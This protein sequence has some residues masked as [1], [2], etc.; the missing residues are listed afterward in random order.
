MSDDQALQPARSAVVLTWTAA[1]SLFVLGV[2]PLANT[3]SAGQAVPWYRHALLVWILIGG[4]A[5]GWISASRTNLDILP[6]GLAADTLSLKL[7][8]Y[9]KGNTTYSRTLRMVNARPSGAIRE[10]I[11][12]GRPVVANVSATSISLLVGYDFVCVRSMYERSREM[13][14]VP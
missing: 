14:Y 4:M 3:L 5:L 1:L 6:S 13:T 9:S 10:G 11:P 2:Y 7:G 8:I 12:P